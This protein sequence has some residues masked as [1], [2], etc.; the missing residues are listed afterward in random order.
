[1]YMYKHLALQYLALLPY[2]FKVNV[3]KIVFM[4]CSIVS[5]YFCDLQGKAMVSSKLSSPL[6]EETWN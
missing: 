5:Q 1:M 3:M 6:K 4:I 2:M